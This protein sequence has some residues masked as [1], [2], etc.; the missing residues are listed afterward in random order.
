MA[1]S[2]LAFPEDAFRAGQRELAEAVYRTAVHGRCLLAQ[3]PTGIGKTVGTLFPMLRALPLQ[4]IDKLAYLTCKGTGRITALEALG[5]LRSGIAGRSLRVLTLVPK[6]E[7]CEHP[8]KA[9]HGDACPLA[10]GFDD[11]LPAAREEAV[12]LGWSRPPP[13]WLKPV[14]T[15]RNGGRSRAWPPRRGR[16]SW[17]DSGPAARVWVLRSWGASSPRAWTCRAR[18]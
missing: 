13:C 7:G 3:A 18:C 14:R 16:T 17:R 15:S 9:C 10:R 8:D 2:G 4:G 5:K 12:G 6:D 1:L 11:C